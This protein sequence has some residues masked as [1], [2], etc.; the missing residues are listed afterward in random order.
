MDLPF[1]EE[2]IALD[3]TDA[4]PKYSLPTLVRFDNPLEERD[5]F[6]GSRDAIFGGPKCAQIDEGGERRNKI[7][8]DVCWGLRKKAL[9]S[10]SRRTLLAPWTTQRTCIGDL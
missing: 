7:R 3:A 4:Y 5:A 1:L 8:A 10:G 9:I 2:A 6:H